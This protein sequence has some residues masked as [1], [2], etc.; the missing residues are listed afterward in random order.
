MN[1]NVCIIYEWWLLS[2]LSLK[3]SFYL[4]GRKC[5]NRATILHLYD[6]FNG[7]FDL[8]DISRE[9][10]NRKQN[11]YKIESKRAKL[12]L[13]AL[14]QM[15]LLQTKDLR[16]NRSVHWEAKAMTPV[17]STVVFKNVNWNSNL[18]VQTG[19]W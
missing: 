3:K 1:N 18:K 12:A 9:L 19:I 17:D 4:E 7:H 2:F 14:R 10:R 6:I 5:Q 13:L 16:T 15:L 8:K 11:P